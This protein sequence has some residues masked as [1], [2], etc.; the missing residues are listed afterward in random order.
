M[1]SSPRAA[2]PRPLH[3][4]ELVEKRLKPVGVRQRAATLDQAALQIRPQGVRAHELAENNDELELGKVIGELRCRQLGTAAPNTA[5]HLEDRALRQPRAEDPRDIRRSPTCAV[6]V[7]R[8]EL[9]RLPRPPKHRVRVC[10]VPDRERVDRA[11]RRID[12]PGV[13]APA[14]HIELRVAK[15]AKCRCM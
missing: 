12:G 11:G 8:D 10:K 7:G 4:S 6:R 15:K 14:G 2:V 9:E 13:P 3:A 5:P 1:P